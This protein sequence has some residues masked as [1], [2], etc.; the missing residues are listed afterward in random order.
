MKRILAIA[1][2]IILSGCE[3]PKDERAQVKKRVQGYVSSLYPGWKIIGTSYDNLADD[4]FGDPD[5]DV[6]IESSAGLA[7]TL[8]LYCY[9]TCSER[10]ILEGAKQ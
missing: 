5:I 2:L 6:R 4:D 1:G 8:R 9:M 10:K 3:N 7:K